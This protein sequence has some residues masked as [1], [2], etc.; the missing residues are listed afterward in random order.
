MRR[1]RATAVAIAVTALLSACGPE[2]QLRLDLRTVSVTVPRVIAPALALVPP[3]APPAVAL[4]PVPSVA[5][6][7][8]PSTP[9]PAQPGPVACPPPNQLAV[10]KYAAS[11]VVDQAPATQTFLQRTSGDFSSASGKG[12]FSGLVHV[13]VTDLP[14]TTS[15]SGQ[16][17][18]SW[19][20]QQIDPATKSR[21]VEDYEL[22]L[23]SSAAGASPPGVYLV[24]LA[25]SDPVRGDFTF[26]PVGN[27]IYVL[28]TPVQ[29]AT[30][31]AQY[32]GIATDPHALTTLQLVRN[33]RGRKRI[34]VC[35]QLVDTWT[36]EMS[37]T[38]TSPS[39]QWKVTWNQQ[40]A[41]A[42][43]AADVDE[44]L[45]MS[46]VSGNFTWARRLVNTAVP[47]ETR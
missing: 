13:T 45:E 44:L 35:D 8:P 42:Y 22:L 23:P 12:S 18:K 38:V 27:G 9:L 46:D 32:A 3:S 26:Q 28:P 1:T 30:N 43:G 31:D 41:T 33:V 21:S 17:V 25:W 40:I 4:P 2:S 16:K 47:K 19:R 20:V 39:A 24:G 7:L 34:T 11:T 36:V 5:S 10:P 15:G 37:G 29:V 14:D 6:Q